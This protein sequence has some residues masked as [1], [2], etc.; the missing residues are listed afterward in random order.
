MSL[1]YFKSIFRKSINLVAMTHRDTS[2][3]DHMEF[4]HA[5]IMSFS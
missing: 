5:I 1:A 3:L 2:L 4:N